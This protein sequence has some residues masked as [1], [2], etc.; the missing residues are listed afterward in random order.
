MRRWLRPASVLLAGLALWGCSSSKPGPTPHSSAAKGEPYVIGAMFAIT[1]DASSLG[2]PE[3][4]SALMLEKQ[5]NA[6]GG[7]KGHPLR[8][9]IEDT[10]GEPAE[11]VNAAKRLV[12]RDNVLAIVGPSRTGETMAAIEYAEKAKVPLLSCALAI[13]IVEPVKSWVFKTPASDRS[14]VALMGEYLKKKGLTKVAT[15]SD[16]T[17]FGKGGLAELQAE[18]PKQGLAIV[19]SEEYGPKDVS[20]ETQVTKLKGTPAQAVICWGTPPGPAIVARNMKQLG[21]KVPLICS[22]GVAN[23]K[24]LSLAGEAGNGTLVAAGRLLVRDQIPESDPQQ[25]VLVKFANDYKQASG[26]DADVFAGH[27]WDGIQLVVE[28]LGEVGPDRQKIRDY[29]EQKQRFVGIDGTF[30]FS[31]KDHCGL[32]KDAFVMIEVRDGKWKLLQ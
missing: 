13:S 25:P 28:A 22:Q 8:I 32:S 17:Q 12:E 29:I 4:N 16:N 27:A 11:A 19:A 14:A 20:M 26:T 9:V 3:K 18:L 31:A 1:G 21:L 30:N 24:F 2:I 15:L 23:G 10:K 6:A 5:I 7:I